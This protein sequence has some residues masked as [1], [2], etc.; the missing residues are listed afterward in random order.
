MKSTWQNRS[1]EELIQVFGTESGKDREEAREILVSKGKAAV[2]ALVTL[3]DHP[4]YIFRW[5]AMMTLKNI[6]DKSLVPV[7]IAR[8]T[9][10]EQDIRWIA[11]KGLIHQ[12]ET[13]IKAL[14]SLLI[15]NSESVFAIEGAHHIFNGLHKNNQL[16][17]SFP[18]DTI[19][20]LLENTR[21]TEHLKVVAFKVLHAMDGA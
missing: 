1:I 4:K 7:F 21:H 11:A 20:P 16:P 15:D 6:K 19:M 13:S 10:K 8:L 3:L 18:F 9:D 14:L 12:G 5:E 2:S 17:D